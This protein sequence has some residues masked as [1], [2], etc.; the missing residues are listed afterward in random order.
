MDTVSIPEIVVTPLK[1]IETDGGNVLHGL[2]RGESQYNGF[3]EAYFSWINPGV[4]KAW[5][6]HNQ[7]TMNLVVPV[8]NVRF[9]FTVG[10]EEFLCETIGEDSYQRLTIPPGIWF[11]FQ[12]MSETPS[13]VLNIAD[14]EHDP[15]EVDRRD[16]AAFGFDW[17]G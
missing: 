5:K 1:V 6:R 14:M 4:I 7:M 8:G 12:N 11:G 13:L 15:L 10:N 2:K 9:A 3:A 17:P 16:I